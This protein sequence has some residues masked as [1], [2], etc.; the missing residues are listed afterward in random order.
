MPAGLAKR[1]EEQKAAAK[2]EMERV[3]GEL[4]ILAEDR[5]VAEICESVGE[6]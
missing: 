6:R 2:P 1:L 3:C 5:A 4:P